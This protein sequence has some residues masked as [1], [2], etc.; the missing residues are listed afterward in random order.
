MMPCC[1]PAVSIRRSR[2]S[3]FQLRAIE[4]ICAAMEGFT[5]HA[6]HALA[7]GRVETVARNEYQA[8]EE[9]TVAVAT[10]EQARTRALGKLEQADGQG[11][12][13]V[14]AALEEFVA[15]QG[16]EDM[17]QCLARV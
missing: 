12:E 2:R 8:G 17:A 9:T 13:F 7:H 1:S 14:G 16:I 10:D 4:A 3:S 6:F 15:R 5:K 11:V